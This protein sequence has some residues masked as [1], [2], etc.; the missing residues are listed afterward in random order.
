MMALCT[1]SG[2]VHGTLSDRHPHTGAKCSGA[3]EQRV[4]SLRC[5]AEILLEC[6]ASTMEDQ[7]LGTKGQQQV[8]TGAPCE[9]IGDV[10]QRAESDIGALETM[11]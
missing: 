2:G 9:G 11:P 7:T 5:G 6:L 1:N 8:Q 4:K 3:L 10:I